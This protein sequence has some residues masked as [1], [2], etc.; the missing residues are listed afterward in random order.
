LIA[1]EIRRPDD[2]WNC[3]VNKEL[4]IVWTARLAVACY[5]GRLATDIANRRD[6]SSQRTARRFWT[7]GC[8]ILL[9]HEALVF[10]ILFHWSHAAAY[11]HVARRTREMTGWDSGF[12]LYVNY[13]FSMVWLTDTIL[14]WRD[15]HWPK[16]RAP[17]WIVQLVFAFMMTQATMVFGPPS[18]IPVGL[19][20]MAVLIGLFWYTRNRGSP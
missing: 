16:Q 18:W 8:A 3:P 15:L 13:A 4:L 19:A 6:E 2:L 10:H 7:L 11:D 20:V 14:W 9:I 17:F 5:V 12:G 1:D